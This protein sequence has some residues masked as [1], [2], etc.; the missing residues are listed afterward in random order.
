MLVFTKMDILIVDDDKDIV[1]ML[2]CHF[3]GHYVVKAYDGLQGLSYLNHFCF[4][5]VVSDV[6]MPNMKGDS[7]FYQFMQYDHKDVAKFVFMSGEE[8]LLPMGTSFLR[9][10]FSFDELDKLVGGL[11]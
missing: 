11:L 2:E 9:K 4:D 1:D 10:P 8:H 5:L 7:M 3:S 6:D